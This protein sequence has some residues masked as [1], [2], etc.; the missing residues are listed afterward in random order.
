VDGAVEALLR[1]GP[2]IVFGWVFTVQVGVP[3]P[4]VPLLLAIGA[5]GGLGKLSLGWALLAALGGSMAA[6]LLWYGVGRRWG[7]QALR[8]RAIGRARELFLAHG[9]W[10]LVIGKFVFELNAAVAALA[11]SSGIR[12]SRFLVYEVASTLL[13]AGGWAG[14]GYVLQ[15]GMKQVTA[16]LTPVGVWLIF[17][18]AV[19][20]AAYGAVKYATRQATHTRARGREP[21]PPGVL[22]RDRKPTV[23]RASE[24]SS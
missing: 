24:V 21:A 19:A 10:A 13:W 12:I 23:S 11:G 2:L 14:V 22:G 20:L 15:G 6:D 7:G 3:I 9:L 18:S 1:H 16:T 17:E 4:T 8:V 5:L